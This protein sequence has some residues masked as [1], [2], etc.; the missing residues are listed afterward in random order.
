MPSRG[1][2]GARDACNESFPVTRDGVYV[3]PE[4]DARISMRD[5]ISRRRTEKNGREKLMTARERERERERES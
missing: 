3:M 4:D 1:V 2:Q 5:A